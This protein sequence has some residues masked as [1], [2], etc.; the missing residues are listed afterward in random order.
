VAADL[1]RP[2]GIVSRLASDPVRFEQPD[3]VREPRARTT[4]A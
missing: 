2:L 3:V 4:S 1:A